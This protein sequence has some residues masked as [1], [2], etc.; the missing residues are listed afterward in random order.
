MMYY[1]LTSELLLVT[2]AV[3]DAHSWVER[4]NVL[5]PNGTC[6]ND[7]GFPRVSG[8]FGRLYHCNLANRN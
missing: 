6:L 8:Q 4:L 5:S 2:A 3:A 7:L 1:L